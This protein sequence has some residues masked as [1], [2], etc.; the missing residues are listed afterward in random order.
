MD[1]SLYW[2]NLGHMSSLAEQQ[3]NESYSNN[4]L[5]QMSPESN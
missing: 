3:F 1:G 5:Q 4:L 2:S